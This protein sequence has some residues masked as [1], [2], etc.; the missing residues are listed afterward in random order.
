[1]GTMCKGAM[2]KEQGA[3]KSE[4]SMAKGRNEGENPNNEQKGKITKCWPNEK[5]PALNPMLRLHCKLLRPHWLQVELRGWLW[6]Q[7][8][9]F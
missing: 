7:A 1:M 3:K 4:K 5:G 9:A 8:R 6:H 2:S